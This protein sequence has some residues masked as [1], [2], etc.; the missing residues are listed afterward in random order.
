M[1][2]F[3]SSFPFGASRVKLSPGSGWGDSFHH[4]HAPLE[5]I[6]HLAERIR[7]LVERI[8][9]LVERIRVA[10]CRIGDLCFA[11]KTIPMMMGDGCFGIVVR[12]GRC[13]V[14]VAGVDPQP[15]LACYWIHPFVRF[16]GMGNQAFVSCKLPYLLGS[17]SS[18]LLRRDRRTWFWKNTDP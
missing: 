11:I 9:H 4:T 7:V 15:F 8:R 1:G 6:R 14:N 17:L 10:D 3:A 2:D 16:C 5:R 12:Q 13:L 18:Q